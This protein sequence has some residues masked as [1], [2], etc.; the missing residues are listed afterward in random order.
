MVVSNIVCIVFSSVSHILSIPLSYAHKY[1]NG[2]YVC[3][4]S[5]KSL[6]KLMRLSLLYRFNRIKSKRITANASNVEFR[7]KANHPLELSTT[8]YRERASA[9]SVIW[10]WFSNRKL[11]EIRKRWYQT[12]KQ[13]DIYLISVLVIRLNGWIKYSPEFHRF[14][15]NFKW[16]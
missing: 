14:N 7:L 15:S 1:Q 11:Y 6:L 3:V 16:N 13:N 5:S 4:F 2:I 12:Q 8:R 9:S 10:D